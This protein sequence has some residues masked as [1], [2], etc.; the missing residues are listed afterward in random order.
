MYRLV[1]LTAVVAA[2]CASAG[3]ARIGDG[4]GGVDSTTVDACSPIPETCNGEDD[5]CDLMIDETFAD[6]GTA[7]TVGM[8]ACAAG[9]ISVCNSTGTELECNAQAGSPATESCDGLDNDCDGNSDESFMVGKPCDGADGDVCADGVYEC[10]SLTA[11]ACNDGPDNAAERCDSFDNDCDG[12]TDEGFNLGAACDGADS[13]LC[14]EG[15]IVCNATGGA[16][17]GDVSSNSVEVCNGADDDCA[18]GADDPWPVG[19]SCTVG[20]G[21]CMRSGSLLCNAGGTNV[22]CSANAGAPIT[23]V[24]GNGT[25]EDCNGADAACPANDLASGAIDIT[26]GGVFTVDLAAAHDDNWTHG[27]GC[28]MQGGRDVFYQFVLPAPEVVYYD[29]FGSSFDSVVRVFAGSCAA[30]GAV[31]KCSDDAC[32]Q[33]RSQGA[34]ELA[35][36]SYCLVVDQYQ[37]STVGGAATLTFR[38]GGRTGVALPSTSG[39]VTGTT[40]GKVNATVAS[41]EANSNQPDVAHF[42]TSCPGANSISA[43]TCTGTA[44]DTVIY[45]RTGTATTDVACSDDSSGCGNNL[46]SRITGASVSGAN[47]QWVIVDG[48]G[49]TGNGAYTLTY[50][51]Q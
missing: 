21:L 42:L 23:E 43:S 18:N 44:F 31:Q 27:V 10:T 20:L 12:N 25:D 46:Q 29:T 6:K 9:G 35:A 41:C 26:A 5:D 50:S 16:K 37:A 51:I 32:T 15:S 40:A 34:I 4:D 36:G 24:C 13:D 48:F 39:S 2:G 45:L 47:L 33:Q 1:A 38:R 22:A 14:M 28:G 8:G 17:C 30:L 7:C 3:E 19:Q 11:A 49:T